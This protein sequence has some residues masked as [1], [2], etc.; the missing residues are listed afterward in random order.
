MPP[1]HKCQLSRDVPFGS[2]PQEPMHHRCAQASFSEAQ[3]TGGSGGGP[4]QKLSR[5]ARGGKPA[6]RPLLWKTE[7]GFSWLSLFCALGRGWPVPNH[8][9]H[10]T[11]S[12]KPHW[13]PEPGDEGLLPVPEPQKRWGGGSGSKTGPVLH[14]SSLW[15]ML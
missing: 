10:G 8:E 9:S 6:N 4:D 11:H 2:Q 7:G 14:K 13:F 3:M 5:Q 15:E 12:Q 1:W